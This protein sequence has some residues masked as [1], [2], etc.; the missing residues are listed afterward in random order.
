M[1]AVGDTVG[2]MGLEEQYG[3]G[4]RLLKKLGYV[5]GTGLGSQG[6]GLATPIEVDAEQTGTHAGLGMLSGR[7]RVSED[8]YSG[9]SSEEE[10]DYESRKG[11]GSSRHRNVK[12]KKTSV[13]ESGLGRQLEALNVDL[14]VQ[15]VLRNPH[16]QEIIEGIVNR[17]RTLDAVVQKIALVQL[18]LDDVENKMDVI[19]NINNGEA[20]LLQKV[21]EL[22][23]IEDESMVDDLMAQVLEQEFHA[24]DF[25]LNEKLL[26]T[27]LPVVDLLHFTVEDSGK[28]LNKAQTRLYLILFPK[29]EAIFK[30][31][32]LMDPNKV[33]QTIYILIEFETIMKF[34]SVYDL[35]IEQFI[36]PKLHEN[37]SQWSDETNSNLH[38]LYDFYV[39]LNKDQRRKLRTWMIEVFIKYCDDWYHRDSKPFSCLHFKDIIGSD[40]FYALTKEH[41]FPLIIE[42][43]F[44]RHFE[45]GYELEGWEQLD[46]TT[47]GPIYCFKKV[48]EYCEF[49]DT[50]SYISLI[51]AMCNEIKKVITEWTLYANDGN[52]NNWK[53]WVCHFLNTIFDANDRPLSHV[54]RTQL[55]EIYKAV[56]TANE[57]LCYDKY[58]DIHSNLKIKEP[59][60]I[61]LEN[62]E[63]VIEIDNNDHDSL[64]EDENGYNVTNIPL[65]RVKPTLREV[66][67]DY[68]EEHGYIMIKDNSKYTQIPYGVDRNSLVPVLT[69]QRLGK[70]IQRVAIKD[71]ILWIERKSGFE[72]DYLYNLGL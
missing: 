40:K 59:V 42:Q 22:L 10:E 52:N 54:E 14:D 16:A 66:L 7:K 31:F 57:V 70:P 6:Q 4:A 67:Q 65:R 53:N 68:C 64:G 26:D 5:E 48:R 17:Q 41:L 71:D 8:E 56:T 32:D 23:K 39:L 3:F 49:F 25:S 21:E 43:L 34:I 19:N 36:L 20:P 29:I 72:P 27:L 33:D 1:K 47:E 55:I 12:F 61:D 24:L 38:Y 11:A 60:L 13:V 46:H 18:E 37:L 30:G 45:P 35:V 50:N 9:S 28:R 63:E 62:D 2:D 15:L 44:D 58:F 51:Y 69:L